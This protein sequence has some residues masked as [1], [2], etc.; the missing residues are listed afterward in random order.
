M[1]KK[2]LSSAVRIQR[3]REE[4][5][6]KK[7]AADKRYSKKIVHTKLPWYVI[8]RIGKNRGLTQGSKPLNLLLRNKD[9]RKSW[10]RKKK[11]K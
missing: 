8:A 6:E 3:W 9:K 4:K 2:K 1:E 5:A 10:Q 7:K 11:E